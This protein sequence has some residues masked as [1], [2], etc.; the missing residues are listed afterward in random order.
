LQDLRLTPTSHI[1]LG[2]LDAAGGD[3]ATP[4]DLK[5]V[6]AL[7]VDN[8]WSTPHAQ[9]YREVQRLADA[10]LLSER[11]EETGRRR[12]FYAITETGRAALDAWRHE[13][14]AEAPQLRD[15]GVLKLFF[16]GDP[17]VVAAHQLALHA[18]KLD[19][20]RELHA[21]AGAG[22]TDGMRRALEVGIAHERAMIDV[23]RQMAEAPTSGPRA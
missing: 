9:V 4:Y 2:L 13:A 14:P 21:Q 19:E 12:R 3:E 8:F 7:S 18:A 15:P 17:A 20:Y 11:R 1:V 5:A 16:G 10:G 23:W 6:M 22:M